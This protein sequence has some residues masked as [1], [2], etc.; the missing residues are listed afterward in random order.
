[1][2]VELYQRAPPLQLAHDVRNVVLR[3][4]C[5]A[6]LEYPL[7]VGT[8][9][10]PPAQ[11]DHLFDSNFDG[12]TIVNIGR[13]GGFVKPLV[14]IRIAGVLKLAAARPADLS[15]KIDERP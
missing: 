6:A 12:L 10:G 14:F 8:D 15:L 9:V 2:P 7:R 11:S 4:V 1:M 5:D 3:R 13:R